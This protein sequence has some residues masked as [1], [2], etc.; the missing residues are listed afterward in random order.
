MNGL[1]S[2]VRGDMFVE[3][4]K[5]SLELCRSGTHVA[6]T[7]LSG[8]VLR[9]QLQTFGSYG[10]EEDGCLQVFANT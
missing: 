3:V 2:S 9:S 7:E 1:I 8:V 4:N 6:P 5:L 10:A